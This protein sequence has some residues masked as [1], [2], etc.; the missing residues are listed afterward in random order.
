MVLTR[1][2]AL[3]LKRASHHTG[4]TRL[5][6]II[7]GILRTASLRAHQGPTIVCRKCYSQR[8]A[9]PSLVE[10]SAAILFAVLIAEPL[11]FRATAADVEQVCVKHK[12]TTYAGETIACYSDAGCRHAEAMGGDPVRDYDPA[13]A[14]YALARGKIA[15]IIT[16]SR[17]L[18]KKVREVG[19]SCSPVS[20]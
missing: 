8:S 4:E 18:A 13:S 20:F 16:G 9:A 17:A 12:Q 6:A 15:A 3:G 10:A 5:S 7:A 1:R 11:Q 14:P 2:I 19:G